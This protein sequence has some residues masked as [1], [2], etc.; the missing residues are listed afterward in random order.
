MHKIEW[1]G[2]DDSMALIKRHEGFLGELSSD[3]KFYIVK[4]K[5]DEEVDLS[6]NE[7]LENE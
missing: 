4:N 5:R 2:E 6:V 1:I 7:V 3:G